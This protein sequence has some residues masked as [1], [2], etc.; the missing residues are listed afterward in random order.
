MDNLI[1][2]SSV[3]QAMKAKDILKKHGIHSKVHRIPAKKGQGSCSYG[4]LIN[5]RL[6]EAVNILSENNIKVFGRAFGEN[7]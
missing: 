1:K 2:L 5:K 7:V 4:L 3:T 6:N